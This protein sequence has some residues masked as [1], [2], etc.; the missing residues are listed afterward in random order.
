MEGL[1]ISEVNFLSVVS[2]TLSSRIDSEYFKKDFLSLDKHLLSKEVNKLSKVTN[3]IVVGFVGEM[4]SNYR[5]DGII[6][7]QTKNIN[8]FFPSLNDTIKITN[9]FHHLL[10]KSQVKNKDILIARSG[11]FGKAAIY[12]ED[13]IVN[14]SDII[15]IEANNLMVNPFFLTVFLN[16]KFGSGQMFRFASGGLQ[17]HVNLTILE[18]LIVPVVK[19]ELQKRIE[20]LLINAY[21]VKKISENNLKVAEDIILKELKI[22]D[23][24]ISKE[25]INIKN[26]KESYLTSSRLDA[27]YY[28]KKYEE[29]EEIIKSFKLGFTTVS[30]EFALSKEIIDRTKDFYNY[31]EISDVNVSDGSVTYNELFVNDLPDNGKMVLKEGQIIISKVRPYRGAIGIIRECPQNYVGSGAFTILYEKS[32]YK[33]EVLQTLLRSKPYQEL[34]MKYNVGSSYPVVKDEDI[35]NLPI[36]KLDK[37]IQQDIVELVEESFQLKKQSEHLLEVAKKAVEIAIE[38]N[39][40]TALKYIDST[41]NAI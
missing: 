17:G 1:E 3:K 8:S 24:R 27:E 9:E 23:I 34:I 4:V 15:I 35:L 5:V 7:L 12:M 16:S 28:Q 29:I 30:Y 2:H 33:K 11:S 41:L 6:L 21:N 31:T 22:R 37:Q 36:P 26:F 32:D 19:M 14:S 38:E 25:N 40:E 10:K 18:E 20:N 13:D 39:E